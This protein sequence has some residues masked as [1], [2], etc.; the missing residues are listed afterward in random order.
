MP[1]SLSALGL[2]FICGCPGPALG[3]SLNPPGPAQPILR[4]QQPAAKALCVVVLQRG[5]ETLPVSSSALCLYFSTVQGQ[6]WH[7]LEE[8][9]GYLGDLAKIRMQSLNSPGP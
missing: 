6:G 4:G 8:C 5:R 3:D 7:W 2:C 9:A 1:V